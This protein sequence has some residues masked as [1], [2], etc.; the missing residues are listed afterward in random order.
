MANGHVLYHKNLIDLAWHQIKKTDISEMRVRHD[1]AM[2][3]GLQI[4]VV[5]FRVHLT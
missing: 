4:R 1:D 5:Q 3:F 2:Y